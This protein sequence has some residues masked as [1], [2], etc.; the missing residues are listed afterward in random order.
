MSSRSALSRTDR[1]SAWA[2]DCG[3]ANSVG[4]GAVDTLPR[5]GLRPTNPHMAEGI[6]IDP[7]PSVPWPAGTM[8]AATAAAVPPEEPPALRDSA[9][10]LRVGP[11]SSGSVLA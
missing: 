6:R 10:G 4:T 3:E 5:D 1:V 11:W 2:T 9:Y 7:P 8:P